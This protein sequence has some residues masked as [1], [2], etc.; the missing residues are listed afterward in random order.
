MGTKTVEGEYEPSNEKQ[1]FKDLEL[2]D[3]TWVVKYEF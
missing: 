2:L 3:K 1:R